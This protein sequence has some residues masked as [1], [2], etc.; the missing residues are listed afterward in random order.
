MKNAGLIR[1]TL[2]SCVAAVACMTML[3]GC[4]TS[5]GGGG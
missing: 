4:G 3:V 5:S 1:R 2:T